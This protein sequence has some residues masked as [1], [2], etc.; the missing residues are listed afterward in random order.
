MEARPLPLPSKPL[1]KRDLCILYFILYLI[2]YTSAEARPPRCSARISARP[3]PPSPHLIP[4][5]AP[6]W[7]HSTS[8]PCRSLQ[9][10]PLYFILYTLYFIRYRYDPQSQ[11]AYPGDVAVMSKAVT[12]LEEKLKPAEP[13]PAGAEGTAPPTPALDVKAREAMENELAL[14]KARIT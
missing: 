5:L 3:S 9:I 8:A 10:R 1:Q 14:A 11:T 12:V 6:P 4:S 2:L 13:A 7:A